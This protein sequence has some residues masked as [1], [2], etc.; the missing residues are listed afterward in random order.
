MIPIVH[1]LFHKVEAFYKARVA[2]ILNLKKTSQKWK[3]KHKHRCKNPQESNSK[4]N[5]TVYKNNCSP[6]SSGIYFMYARLA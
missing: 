1:H 6:Q 3:T 2:L 4:M 5:P